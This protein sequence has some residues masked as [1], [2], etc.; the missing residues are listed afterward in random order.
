MKRWSKQETLILIHQYS[1]KNRQRELALYLGR[2]RSSINQKIVR[3][4]KQNKIENN[5]QQNFLKAL[6]R[7]NYNRTFT[8]KDLYLSLRC[9]R[10]RIARLK[11]MGLQ[12]PDSPYDKSK[13]DLL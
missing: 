7:N 12:I 1:I 11:K 5:W 9:V 6:E 3:L 10:Y 4:K 8:A 2:S 13:R